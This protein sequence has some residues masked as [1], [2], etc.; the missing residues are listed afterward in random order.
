MDRLVAIRAAIQALSQAWRAR[1]YLALA[2]R[3]DADVVFAL[4]GFTAQL[5][6][7]AALV[8]SYRE[9]MERVTLTE[10]T[11]EPP[12]I[13]TWS[14]CPTVVTTVSWSMR[15]LANGV[16]NRARGHEVLLLRPESTAPEGWLVAWRT[17]LFTEDTG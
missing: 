15:W 4:P 1:D 10:Y 7:R 5:S 2:E 16:E 12:T 9:F 11:E 17:L 6:G 13:A 3:L 14:D 8:D